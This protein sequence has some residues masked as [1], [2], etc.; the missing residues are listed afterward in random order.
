MM[1]WGL[2]N[3]FFLLFLFAAKKKKVTKRKTAG[4]CFEAAANRFPAE[5]QELA[6]L[7]QPALL[8]AVPR[9]SAFS[10]QNERPDF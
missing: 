10:P 7:R 9:F 6:S 1:V 2:M 4:C 3:C 5:A 8:F